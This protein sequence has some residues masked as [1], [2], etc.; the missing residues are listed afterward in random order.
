[1]FPV[2]DLFPANPG[3]QVTGATVGPGT[4]VDGTQ[5]WARLVIA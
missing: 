5:P 1:M 3:T 2:R 4:S